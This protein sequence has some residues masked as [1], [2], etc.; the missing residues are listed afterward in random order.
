MVSQIE[1]LFPFFRNGKENSFNNR[2]N[3]DEGG[4]ETKKKE[5]TYSGEDVKMGLP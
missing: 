5:N 1:N 4:T 2:R 3:R